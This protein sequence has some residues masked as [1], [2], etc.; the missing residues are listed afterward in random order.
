MTGQA[1]RWAWLEDAVGALR[2]DSL[3]RELAGPQPELLDLSSNDYLGLSRD[4]RVL[5]AAQ[6]VHAGSG[7]SRLLAGNSRWHTDLEADLAK[8]KGVEAA[9]VF[10]AGYLVNT[11]VLPAL[12]GAQDL[13]LSD[14]LNHASVVDGCRLA[15]AGGSRVEIYPHRDAAV[16]EAILTQGGYRHAFVVTDGVFSMDGDLAPLGE[17]GEACRRSGAFLIVDDAHGT[18]VLGPG[19]R[20]TAQAL[21]AEEYV[22]VRIGTLSKALGAQGGFVAGPRILVEYLVNR[23]RTFIFATGLAPAV[24]AAAREALQVIDSDEG[25]RRRRRVLA[26]AQMFRVELTGMGYSVPEGE[27]PIIPVRVGESEA[28]LRLAAAL[29]REGVMA[30]AI[31]PPTVAPGTARLRLSV[32]ADLT[33]AAVER[34]LVAFRRVRSAGG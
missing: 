24:T 33:D 32:R 34:G 16:V 12:A 5:A 9:L 2:R 26:L 31:R 3:Y 23:C 20:G 30:P 6:T 14:A 18:G 7:G 11:G 8:F 25:A 4:H 28:A 29:R 22:D 19:G 1:G 15:R 17:L 27:T 21:G 10:S 13:I